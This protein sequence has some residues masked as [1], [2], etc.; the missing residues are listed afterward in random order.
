MR[1]I[2]KI[3]CFISSL[4]RTIL[5]SV[6]IFFKAIIQNFKLNYLIEKR[7]HAVIL[8]LPQSPRYAF[9][10]SF[11]VALLSSVIIPLL[12]FSLI[13]FVTKT[14]LKQS[15]G[16]GQKNVTG[17]KRK[18][19]WMINWSL[20]NWRREIKYWNNQKRSIQWNFSFNYSKHHKYSDSNQRGNFGKT[21]KMKIYC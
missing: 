8:S 12:L 15:V 9:S 4:S 17:Q 21:V 7:N 18:N 11:P 14:R 5:W 6:F 20:I 19:C 13:I 1:W 3:I 16:N 10:W 2:I